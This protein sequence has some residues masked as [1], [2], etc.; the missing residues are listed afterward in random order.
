MR[1]FRS[2]IFHLAAC[3]TALTVLPAF[4]TASHKA[5]S[6]SDTVVL[7]IRHAEKPDSGVGL[8]P[9]GEQRASAYT[10]FFKSYKVNGKP[11]KISHLIA[12]SDSKD[13][14]RPRLTLEPLAQ[15][16]HDPLDLRFSDK[17]PEALVEALKNSDMGPEIVICWRHG[18]IPA[19]L[20]AL[21]ADS[22]TFIP[23]GKWPGNIYDRVIELHFDKDGKVISQSSHLV[24]E[25]LL[26]GDEK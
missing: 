21:G 17:D 1:R 12:A 22:A 16:L 14:H 23:E 3:A 20:N 7:I 5:K 11:L 2:I 13:S 19:L 6:L 24:M 26:P 25:H 18:K 10:Q 4:G 8:T 15:A 9:I